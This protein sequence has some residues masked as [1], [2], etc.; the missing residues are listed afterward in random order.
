MPHFVLPNA[1]HSTITT[2]NQWHVVLHVDVVTASTHHQCEWQQH[3]PHQEHVGA[4]ISVK[5]NHILVSH[6]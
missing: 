2:H 1:D 4:K 6:T 5:T 3:A